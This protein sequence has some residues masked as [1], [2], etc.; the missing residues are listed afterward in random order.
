VGEKLGGFG[1]K[2]GVDIQ[3]GGFLFFREAGGF[4]K[5]EST[6]D[7]LPF[8]ISVWKVGSDIARAEGSEN[9]VCESMKKDI[10]IGVTFEA[11]FVGNGDAAKD[12][13][14]SRDK[15]MNI[16]TK[17]NS[18]HLETM[19]GEVAVANG[20]YKSSSQG[21]SSTQGEKRNIVFL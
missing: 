4:C 16:I 6:G 10:G 8:W 13:R 2:S 1:Q 19:S 12:E 20:F 7:I 9:C 14:A 21:K 3:D 17:A 18:Q 15:G 11:P 5:E